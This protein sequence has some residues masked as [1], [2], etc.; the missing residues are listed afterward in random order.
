MCRDRQ[1]AHSV[2][3]M[4]DYSTLKS[5]VDDRRHDLEAAASRPIRFRRRSAARHIFRRPRRD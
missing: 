5:L 2:G 3:M 1:E 4:H